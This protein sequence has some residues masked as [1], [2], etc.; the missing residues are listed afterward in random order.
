MFEPLLGPS[1]VAVRMCA[2]CRCGS[3]ITNVL[4]SRDGVLIKLHPSIPITSQLTVCDSIPN[5]FLLLHMHTSHPFICAHTYTSHCMHFHTTHTYTPTPHMHTHAPSH[6]NHTP[7]HHTHA[8]SH[9][10]YQARPISL[11]Y[12]KLE[13]GYTTSSE[14][15]KWV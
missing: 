14:R 5:Q 15:E 10:V 4:H 11:A 8:P 6:H 2:P 13:L 12:W 3:E 9:L 1:S 7:S